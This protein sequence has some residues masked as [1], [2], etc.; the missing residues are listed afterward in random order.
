MGTPTAIC[1]GARG[2]FFGVCGMCGLIGLMFSGTLCLDSPHY[3]QNGA[4]RAV[5]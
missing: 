5:G 1:G 3:N 4:A 2:V